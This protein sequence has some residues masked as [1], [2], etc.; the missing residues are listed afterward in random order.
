MEL[1]LLDALEKE[2]KKMTGVEVLRDDWNI[3]QIPDH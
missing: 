3:A 2:L 1:P